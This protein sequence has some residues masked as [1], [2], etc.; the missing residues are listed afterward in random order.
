MK[1]PGLVTLTTEPEAKARVLL[2]GM[3]FGETPLTD[4]EITPGLHR[5]ELSPTVFFRRT[6]ELE[7]RGAAERQS[8][9]R[10]SRRT[11]RR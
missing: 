11:G 9:S 1:L 5:L 7:V 10:S 8:L 6:L 2:D 4:A 3:P